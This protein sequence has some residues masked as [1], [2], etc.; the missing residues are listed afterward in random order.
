MKRIAVVD[1]KKLKDINLKRHIQG[2]CPVNRAGTEC[3]KIEK[4]D[5]LTI[6]EI[7]C[8]GCGICVKAAPDAIKIVNLPEIINR[9]PIHR[10]GVNEF[11]LFSLP[12]P[13]FGSVVGILGINGIGKSTAISILAGLLKPNFDN[14][15]KKDFDYKELIEFFKGTEMQIF[16]EKVRKG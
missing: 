4:D 15:K 5:R 10:Y 11:A 9:K 8:I 16:F 14:L 2:L 7:T 13:L 1:N 3:I 12:M 6:D